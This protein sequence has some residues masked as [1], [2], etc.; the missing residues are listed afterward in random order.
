M[1]SVAPPDASLRERAAAAVLESRLGGGSRR[2]AYHA[3]ATSG[4][5]ERL[6]RPAASSSG[7]RTAERAV[8]SAGS[9]PTG[10]CAWLAERGRRDR[11]H[12]GRDRGRGGRPLFG[13]HL[14][15]TMRRGRD[16]RRGGTPHARAEPQLPRRSARPA[17]RCR[18]RCGLASPRGR[19]GPAVGVA[20]R[21][22][23][24]PSRCSRRRARGALRFRSLRVGLLAAPRASS[25]THVG[26][27]SAGS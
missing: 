10:S 23:S 12:A 19:H 15:E 21:R 1:P 13:P 18:R 25:L 7:A 3:R 17:A 20:A 9:R 4:L 16:P 22:S 8:A 6:S 14:R 27:R 2:S 5:V 11:L 26:I 24:T